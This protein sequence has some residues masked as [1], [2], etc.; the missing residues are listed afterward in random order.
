M[1]NA[2]FGAGIA[3]RVSRGLAAGL[4]L[5]TQDLTPSAHT[6]LERLQ[7]MEQFNW[8]L[9]WARARTAAFAGRTILTHLTLSKC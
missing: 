2:H 9:L 5:L 4:W 7:Q 3:V 1:K 6:H 8:A